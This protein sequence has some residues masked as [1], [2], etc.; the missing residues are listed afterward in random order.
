MEFDGKQ[1]RFYHPV[2]TGFPVLSNNLYLES[3]R[4]LKKFQGFGGEMEVH[5]RPGSNERFVSVASM[6]SECHAGSPIKHSFEIL[7]TVAQ[8]DT[9]WSIVYDA[10]QLTL[11]LKFHGSQEIE[12][13]NLVKVLA[14][15]SQR[16][17]GA[18]VSNSNLKDPYSFHSVSA[19]ENRE[20]I[21]NVVNQ[22]GHEIDLDSRKELLNQLIRYSNKYIID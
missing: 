15:K 14:L 3:I 21:N 2:A 5:H 1:Y 8:S 12:E 11:Y 7:D 16:T 17:L 9:R 22:L 13:I 20:L 19:E 10:T 18:D 6:L 4:Y